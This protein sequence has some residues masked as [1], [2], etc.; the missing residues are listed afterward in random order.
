M[1]LIE[2]SELRGLLFLL[3]SIVLAFIVIV[4]KGMSDSII[5]RAILFVACIAFFVLLLALIAVLFST[6]LS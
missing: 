6:G 3:V 5:R 1:N 4:S 2:D